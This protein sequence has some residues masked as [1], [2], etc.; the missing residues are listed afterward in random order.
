MTEIH[1]V[2]DDIDDDDEELFVQ[3]SAPSGGL[4]EGVVLG[5]RGQVIL[6]IDNDDP[7]VTVTFEVNTRTITEG[8]TSVTTLFVNI[9]VPSATW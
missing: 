4:P 5:S 3:M 9:D 6:I 1:A 2:D 8:S 7:H